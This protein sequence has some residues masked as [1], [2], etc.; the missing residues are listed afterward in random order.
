MDNLLHF[1]PVDSIRVEREARQRRSFNTA[2][3]EASIPKVGLINP[4]IVTRDLVLVAGERRL[5]A[6]KR[7]K[8]SHIQ[9]RYTD[10]LSTP[11][12]RLIELEENLRRE[13]LSWQDK[14]LAFRD[15]F[16]LRR[17]DKPG[18][19]R[20]DFS[21]SI[22]YDH[23]YVYKML[24]AAD[25]IRSGNQAVAKAATYTKGVNVITRK[26][27]READNA[28]S[29][30]LDTP[31][32][33]ADSTSSEPAV[34]SEPP[35]RILHADFLAWAADYS[36]P[37]FNFLHC[38]FPYGVDLDKSDQMPAEWETYADAEGIYWTLLEGLA[39][40]FERIVSSSA[41]IM[42]WFSMKHY[43]KT[44]EFFE[45]R[46]P[47]V[48]LDPFPLVWLKSDNKGIAPDVERLPR[49]VYE[50]ALFGRVGDRKSL[51][52]IAN[53]YAAPKPTGLH[54]SE[55]PEPVLRHFFQMVVDSH[56]RM[57]DPTCGGG[58]AI[59]AAE[60]MGAGTAVG[61]ELNPEFAQGAQSALILA[62]NKRSLANVVA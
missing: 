60:S 10:E 8:L 59:R 42:F 44:L 31:A 22:G 37:K 28:I 21:A 3:L 7:L 53:A 6:H 57:L 51:K 33:E 23:T 16:D 54:V 40:S 15:L 48:E 32:G 34:S 26:N 55:K 17:A 45:R 29:M 20:Q 5:E 49:R 46:L 41:H 30:L 39:E 14:A 19:T 50:T 27:E 11:E 56:T 38:D 58:S 1:I 36:G 13:D 2:D 62:R 52:L 47:R 24:M 25:E 35:A 61:I 43:T 4:I 18:L 9:V 12:L